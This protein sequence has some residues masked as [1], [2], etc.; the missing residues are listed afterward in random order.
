MERDTEKGLGPAEGAREAMGRVRPARIA[1]QPELS[2]AW[3]RRCGSQRKKTLWAVV[4]AP[5]DDGDR[6][7]EWR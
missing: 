4:L 2:E 3:L 1:R 6:G 7:W 5:R